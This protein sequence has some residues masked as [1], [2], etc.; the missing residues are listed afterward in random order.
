MPPTT[1][2]PMMRPVWDPLPLEESV[3]CVAEAAAIEVLVVGAIVSVL[4]T[5][6]PCAEL[7]VVGAAVVTVDEYDVV[8]G[9][10][11]VEL[12]LVL[13]VVGGTY[14]VVVLGVYMLEGT[15]VVEYDE[16]YVDVGI[17]DEEV[18]VILLPLKLLLSPL[19]FP[20]PTSRG[21][22]LTVLRTM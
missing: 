5:V 2:T 12:E 10:V 18:S 16:M 7:D 15:A 6:E 9:L 11:R 22:S 1:D 19:L 13:V 21:S 14:V 17:S 4:K 3:D 20:K 8:V